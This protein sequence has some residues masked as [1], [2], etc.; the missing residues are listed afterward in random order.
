VFP[1][2]IWNL[3]NNLDS[4]S[5]KTIMVENFGSY[6]KH[7]REL[8]GVPLEEIAEV[9][10]VHIRFL[11]ALENNEF[12]QLPGEVFIKGYIRS[13]AK[14]IGLD[15]EEMI[16]AYDENV[17]KDR[18]QELE[19]AHLASEKIRSRKQ[20]LMGY[21]IGGIGLAGIL[22][23]G[24]LGIGSLVDEDNKEGVEQLSASDPASNEVELENL[25]LPGLPKEDDIENAGNS[26]QPLETEVS[27]E[28]PSSAPVDSKAKP[29]AHAEST[30]AKT[31]SERPKPE[32][33]KTKPIVT[34]SK[35][36]VVPSTSQEKKKEKPKVPAQPTPNRSQSEVDEAEVATDPLLE[37]R[38]SVPQEVK[39]EEPKT[40]EKP[41]ET[42]KDPVPPEKPVIIQEVVENPEEAESNAETL[43]T[44]SKRLHLMI[45]VQGNSWFN[46]TV[47]D[48]GEED[49]I[50]PGGSSKN[51][52]G[53]E[54]FRVT[55]G[56]RR[57]TRMFLNGQSLDLPFGTS[58]VIRDFDITAKLIE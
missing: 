10:K 11:E 9:T 38:S 5:E 41:L 44:D 36:K 21:A 25:P 31:V 29:D 26:S 7:E 23:M 4:H 55:I 28:A 8:R 42:Q 2:N 40:P 50:L 34:D 43:A 51:I 19:N 12:D 45:Q 30:P 6:L 46:V 3:F 35:L 22:L 54:K 48:G 24:Y 53:S 27:Q 57:G 32:V 49:F 14:V 58:D 56:N 1:E 17:G 37:L 52:Y 47:D 33:E 20:N 16:T 15:S 39:K 13:Y 18:R